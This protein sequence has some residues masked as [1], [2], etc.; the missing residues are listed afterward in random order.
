MG[1]A[2]AE[3]GVAGGEDT[4]RKMVAAV[5][6]VVAATE[7]EEVVFRHFSMVDPS[8][9]CSPSQVLGSEEL[10]QQEHSVAD[11]R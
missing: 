7:G 1:V 11:R 2:G 10:S 9:G 6:A 3:A 8:F 4:S 5:T